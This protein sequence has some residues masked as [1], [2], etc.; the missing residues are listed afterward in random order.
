MKKICLVILAFWFTTPGYALKEYYALSRSVRALGMGGAFYAMS[1]DAR[2]LFYN[3]AGLSFYTGEDQYM[4]STNFQ[5][6]QGGVEAIN[7]IREVTESTKDIGAIA[8]SIAALQGKP[9]YIGAGLFPFYLSKNKAI[10]L[11][12][13]DTKGQFGYLGK[14]LDSSLDMTIIS[15]SGIFMAYGKPVT[16]NLHLG[17][18]AKMIYRVGGRTAF[19]VIDL[20]TSSTLSFDPQNLGGMGGGLDFDLGATYELPTTWLPHWVKEGRLSLTAS[21]LIAGALIFKQSGTPPQLPRYVSFG[22]LFV[23]PGI[24][25]I[26]RFHVLFDLAEFG[27][28]GQTDLDLGARG[29]SV[30][31]K[32]NWGIE[33]P[34]KGWAFP[35]VGFHQGMFTLGLGLDFEFFKTDFAWYAEEVSSGINRLASRRFAFTLTLGFAPPPPVTPLPPDKSGLKANLPSEAA[36]GETDSLLNLM[37]QSEPPT[38]AKDLSEGESPEPLP[39]QSKDDASV[40][41]KDR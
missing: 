24:A 37:E 15:D 35:R 41:Q 26:D 22:S 14:E 2:A 23:L 31:K 9:V 34:I 36:T 4:F 16:E 20:A 25:S 19:S 7:Q 17:V 1:D 13:F 6:A 30:W 39:A 40:E 5:I 28:G 8:A 10:G 32:V 12:L 29:G 38:E 11:L 33:A 21:N 27:L 18:T 3:P